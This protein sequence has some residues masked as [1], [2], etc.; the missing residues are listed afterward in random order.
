MEY[1]VLIIIGLCVIAMLNWDSL[2]IIRYNILGKV[3]EKED[4]NYLICEY[5]ITLKYYSKILKNY[6][7]IRS[8]CKAKITS[9]KITSKGNDIIEL[10]VNCSKIKMDK[11]E[12]YLNTFCKQE[13]EDFKILNIEK[14]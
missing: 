1:V 2:N 3:K 12:N 6:D 10:K 7:I 5:I 11:L 4:E 14:K 8:L 13:Y 9:Y